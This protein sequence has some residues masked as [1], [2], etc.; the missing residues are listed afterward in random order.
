MR[1][2]QDPC[3]PPSLGAGT[4][5]CESH[6]EQRGHT[7]LVSGVA[8]APKRQ[9]FIPKQSGGWKSKIQVLAGLVPPDA[10]LLSPW[11]AVSCFLA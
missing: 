1:T 11:M 2:R 4:L 8:W 3:S 7:G 5:L 6:R 9:I 10:F